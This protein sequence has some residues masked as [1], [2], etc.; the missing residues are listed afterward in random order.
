MHEARRTPRGTCVLWT[1]SIL[2]AWM[3]AM[4]SIPNFAFAEEVEH[5]TN[6]VF[7]FESP[8][9]TFSSKFS[10]ARLSGCAR[11]GEDEYHL[12]I[13]PE[14]S[15]IN[16]SPWYAF[17][18]RS[19]LERTLTVHLHYEKAGHRY[20]PK[21]ST[22]GIRWRSLSEDDY[23]P[24]RNGAILRLDVGP[25]PLWV[26]AHELLT[27]EDTGDWVQSLASLPF[28]KRKD[29]GESVEGRSIEMLDVGNTDQANY[30]FIMAR[31]HPPEVTG[32]IGM[33][34]FVEALCGDS[35]LARR[36]REHYRVAVIPMANPDGVE[37]GHWRFNARGVDLNRD[38]EEFKQ[39]ET[40]AVRDTL[41]SLQ[42]D[43]QVHL[44]LDFHSTHRDMFYTDADTRKGFLAG[45]TRLWLANI[46][47]RFPSY[48]VRRDISGNSR[49]TSRAWVYRNLKIPSITYE[50][51]DDSPRRHIKRIAQA[52]AEEMM[53]LLLVA[54]E[55]Q[56]L[57]ST[58]A[59]PDGPAKETPPP[60]EVAERTD[61]A[62]RSD[63]AEG[64]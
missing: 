63:F 40:R 10:G 43:G 8:S 5:A 58:P 26:A 29:I 18:V 45:F 33:M 42:D 34:Y 39:P 27:V 37:A 9:V 7:K 36:F 47:Q 21:T 49:S 13:R 4:V 22:D 11:A 55:G 35:D 51:G 61:A 41:M 12:L 30:V 15:P 6:R 23:Q 59:A 32:A 54:A 44:F 19:E 3:T 46:D 57:V 25:K 56:T 2:A 62:K 38:W 50:F 16:R 20:M 28:V 52:S 53:E 64:E 31:Q 14:Q 24:G 48:E 17:R 1:A 60:K